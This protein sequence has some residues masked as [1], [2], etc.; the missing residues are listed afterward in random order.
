LEY[1]PIR[2]KR[3][4]ELMK[5]SHGSFKIA[6]RCVLGRKKTLH[7]K[8]ALNSVTI[9]NAHADLKQFKRIHSN[10]MCPVA[11]VTT[12]HIAQLTIFLPFTIHQMASTE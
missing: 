9:G 8:G 6:D 1:N 10:G 2:T 3:P 7:I 12:G 5:R 11:M 4:S